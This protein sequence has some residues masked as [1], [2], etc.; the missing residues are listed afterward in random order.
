MAAYK[1]TFRFFF[2]AFVGALPPMFSLFF[3]R[4]SPLYR[5]PRVTV[6]RRH[7]VCNTFLFAS[8]PVLLYLFFYL[9]CF[10]T[11]C[12]FFSSPFIVHLSF[13][14]ALV[15]NP[16]RG[17][18]CFRGLGEVEKE[19]RLLVCEAGL[20]SLSH[21]AALRS[22][23][24]SLSLIF[25]FYRWFTSLFFSISRRT[26]VPSLASTSV[27]LFVFSA[28]RCV[29]VQVCRNMVMCGCVTNLSG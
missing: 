6:H 10:P 5:R 19:G 20:Y 25:H 15:A 24:L 1:N 8:S 16:V 9:A 7:I 14:G 13:F 11:L 26:C 18:G 27:F 12:A 2:F 3:F 23:S 28:L 4:F 21:L 22:S 29:G 17:E